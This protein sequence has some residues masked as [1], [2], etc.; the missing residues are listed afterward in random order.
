MSS[1][2]Q[3][4][5]KTKR[6]VLK[7]LRKAYQSEKKYAGAS[8]SL[9]EV[10]VSLLLRTSIKLQTTVDRCF[11]PFGMTAQDAAVLVRCAQTREISAGRLAQAMDRDKGKVTRFVDRLEAA[12]YVTRK[13]DPRDRRFFIIKATPSGRRIAPRL[14]LLFEEIRAHFFVGIPTDDME[15]LASVLSRLHE[16]AGNLSRDKAFGDRRKPAGG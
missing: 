7:P 13:S 8:E 5:R 4:A 1:G 11:L 6:L 16:N 10:L 15:F 2:S 9:E 12:S 14:K 3:L